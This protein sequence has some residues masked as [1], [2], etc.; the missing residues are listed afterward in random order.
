MFLFVLSYPDL[1]T[2]VIGNSFSRLGCGI[3]QAFSY[4]F[5]GRGGNKPNSEEIPRQPQENGANQRNSSG[6]NGP[7]SS[8]CVLGG[9]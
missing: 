1:I 7:E 2:K 4:P 6:G 9:E 5:A 3:Y 8:R